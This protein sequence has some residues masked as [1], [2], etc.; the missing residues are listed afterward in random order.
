[1]LNLPFHGQMKIEVWVKKVLCWLYAS[2]RS[3]IA[4]GGCEASG[5][6]AAGGMSWPISWQLCL[7]FYKV[8]L[9]L[10]VLL[11][12]CTHSV[13]LWVCP[14]WRSCI[15]Q[16]LILCKYCDIGC[17]RQP[18]HLDCFISLRHTSHPEHRTPLEIGHA[19][20]RNNQ[21]AIPFHTLQPTC[22]PCAELYFV[23]QSS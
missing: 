16:R 23:W 22:S 8:F 2:S 6:A 3:K 7:C 10:F 1:M 17:T 9:F 12:S 11:Q 15:N 13:R 19:A 20:S 4:T 18:S 14:R 5:S 21:L